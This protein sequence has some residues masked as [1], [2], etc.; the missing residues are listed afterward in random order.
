MVDNSGLFLLWKFVFRLHKC[1]TK[2]TTCR[3]G[4][5]KASIPQDCRK[6][7]RDAGIVGQIDVAA[8]SIGGGGG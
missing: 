8:T 1:L 2:G 5:S 7:L 6:R 4:S 3:D